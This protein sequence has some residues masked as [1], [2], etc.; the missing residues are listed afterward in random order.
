[1]SRRVL[2]CI[3]AAALALCATACGS[4]SSG[5]GGATAGGSPSSA[6]SGAGSTSPTSASSSSPIL[7]G[8]VVPLTGALATPGQF[9]LDGLKAAVSY[10]NANGGILGRQ[11]QLLVED[12]G[13]SPVQAV[14]KFKLLVSKHIQVIFGDLL[15]DYSAMQPLFKPSNIISISQNTTDST[16]YPAT[17]NPNGFNVFIPT[18]GYAQLYVNYL[19]KN[20]HVKKIGVIGGTDDFGTS[21]TAAV[22]AYAP[23]V[24][25][26]VVTQQFP[27]NATSLVTQMRS[28]KNAGA[29]S[30]ISATFAGGQI[31]SIQAQQALGW[32]PPAVT[33]NTLNDSAGVA[34]VKSAGLKNLVGGPVS[35]FMLDSTA[36][37]PETQHQKIFLSYLQKA[38]GKGTS[39]DGVWSTGIIWFDGLLVWKSAVEKAGTTATASVLKVMNSGA[40][41]AGWSGNFT[42]SPSNH[43]TSNVTSIFGLYAGGVDC[44][45]ACPAAKG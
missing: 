17:N 33:S 31:L 22:K 39:L 21:L 25:V 10:V 4:S 11:V 1:M 42:Y 41:L 24:G 35:S 26:Q 36:G 3:V 16:W 32:D 43:V 30:L 27:A 5:S 14:A 23:T 18:R 40:P 7:V 12:S 6:T 8:V 13:G 9:Q 44:P 29:D 45:G 2:G 15:A 37:A 19:V 28:L 38:V 20:Y 34:A